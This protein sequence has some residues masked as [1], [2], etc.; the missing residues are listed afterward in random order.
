[1]CYFYHGCWGGAVNGQYICFFFVSTGY[2]KYN[3]IRADPALCFLERAG[4]PDEKA[5]AAEQRAND[6]IDGYVGIYNIWTCWSNIFNW[7]GNMN[8]HYFFYSDVEDPEYKPAPALFKDDMEV[9]LRYNICIS[10]FILAYL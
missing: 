2:E 8:T 6:Y 9:T 5:V 7:I 1:M 10:A 4:K 3:T